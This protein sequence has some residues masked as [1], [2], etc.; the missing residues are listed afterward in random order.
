MKRLNLAAKALH[1]GLN[2]EHHE[3]EI[4]LKICK[5]LDDALAEIP[6]DLLN[7]LEQIR[8]KS[9]TA[10]RNPP[11]AKSILDQSGR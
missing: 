6:V 11:F 1:V 2:P 7:R 4:S 9:V 3:L 10:H 5:F 8:F